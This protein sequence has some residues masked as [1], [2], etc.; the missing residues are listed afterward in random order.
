MYKVFGHLRNARPHPTE[1][2]NLSTKSIRTQG[3]LSDGP[4]GG[5]RGWQNYQ[6]DR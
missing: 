1:H 5:C 4:I 3:A 2:Q 6:D